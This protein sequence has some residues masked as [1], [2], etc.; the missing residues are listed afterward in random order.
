MIKL[1]VMYPNG[2]DLKFD[3]NYYAKEHSQL[4]KDLLGDAIIASDINVGISGGS[5]EQIAPYVIIS[6]LIFES[7]ES[8]QQSFGAN[9]AKLLADLPN[10][11]NIQPQIQI[12]EIL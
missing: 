2:M 3:K 1:T 6:N 7:L 11:T 10:F 8:F 12:S 4:I 5:P 9:A